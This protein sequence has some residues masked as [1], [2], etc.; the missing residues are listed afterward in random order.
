MCIICDMVE[1]TT[2][3]E[4][5][6]GSAGLLKCIH[7]LYTR[8]RILCHNLQLC[9]RCVG[10]VFGFGSFGQQMFAKHSARE[11]MDEGFN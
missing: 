4:G 6:K 10:S 1:K 3:L 8:F 2:W 5:G 9:A 7:I 11:M